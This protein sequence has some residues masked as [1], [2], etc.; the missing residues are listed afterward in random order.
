MECMAWTAA[1]LPG[2]KQDWDALVEECRGAR[3]EEWIRS[4]QRAGIVREVVS[5][6]ETPEGDSIGI[7]QEAEDLAGAFRTIAR[8]DD[9]FDVWFRQK[10]EDI[11]GITAE[12]LEAPPPARTYL[13]FHG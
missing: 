10:I 13:D 7:F 2:K 12:M 9:P 11:H 4:R 8:S 3:H 1:I 5:L 6:M